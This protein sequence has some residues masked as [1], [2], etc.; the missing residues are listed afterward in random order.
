[1]IVVVLWQHYKQ[2]HEA[3]RVIAENELCW[4][5]PG[6]H[7]KRKPVRTV[8]MPSTFRIPIFGEYLGPGQRRV[9]ELAATAYLISII[10]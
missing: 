4:Y 10:K 3:L 1:M 2:K 6:F 9:S 7:E 8:R 5:I